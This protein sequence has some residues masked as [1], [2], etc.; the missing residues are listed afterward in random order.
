MSPL[1]Q[2]LG[3]M[4]LAGT[5]LGQVSL[6]AYSGYSAASSP[7]DTG[8][9][10][11]QTH[12][13]TAEITPTV[14]V[15]PEAP[16][17]EP[18]TPSTPDI[19]PEPTQQPTVVITED[20]IPP[21]TPEP[22]SEATV[23]PTAEPT[24]EPTEEPTVIPTV[25]VTQELTP[26][27]TATEEPTPTPSSSATSEAPTF[28][29]T[30][31]E[32]S[33]ATPTATATTVDITATDTAT[34]AATSTPSDTPTGTVVNTSTPTP[35]NTPTGTPTSTATSTPTGT[36]TSTA[37]ATATATA[38]NVPPTPTST[39]T[40][41]P[42]STSTPTATASST[43]TA[44]ATSTSTVTPTPTSTPIAP[45]C[46]FS[47][48]NGLVYGA[49]GLVEAINTA[50]LTPSLDV[51]CLTPNGTYVL[52]TLIGVDNGL[53]QITTPIEIR[54]FNATLTRQS[55]A[56]Q[57]RL[58]R[59]TST[60]NLTIISLTLSNGFAPF[61]GAIFSSGVLILNQVTIIDNTAL[62]DGGALY[63]N[64]GVTTV[65]SSLIRFNDSI[66]GGAIYSVG[67]ATQLSITGSYIG[68]NSATNFGGGIFNFSAVVNIS[69]TTIINNNARQGGAIRNQVSGIM[70]LTGS[71]IRNNQAVTSGGGLLIDSPSTTGSGNCFEANTAPTGAAV[72]YTSIGAITPL[73]L[74]NNWWGSSLGAAPGQLLGLIDI[75]PFLTAPPAFCTGP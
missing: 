12:H 22:T 65:I 75:V 23:I 27:P 20:P 4:L 28:T 7:V 21:V 13:G 44:T 36:P 59:V 54:G 18:T 42:T 33:S 73:N 41:T 67:T 30:S 24:T 58:L 66:L 5:L 50:N 46:T 43:A 8:I 52:T 34:T 39:P 64:N 57:F 16:T 6:I 32:T 72:H 74:E 55:T 35:T 53:P 19:T 61:G 1:R 49:G 71:R 45:G 63:L 62:S 17:P 48:P 3:V 40:A 38:S 10:T 26:T 14:Q 70:T 60:G 9:H 47:I 2:L 51:I 69:G 11:Q 29:P 31:E 56:P 37:S 25:D 68:G 15:T